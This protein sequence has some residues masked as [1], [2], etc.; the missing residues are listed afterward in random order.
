MRYLALVQFLDDDY[1]P[2]NMRQALMDRIQRERPDLYERLDIEHQ[3][4]EKE[5]K[6]GQ[7]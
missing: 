3:K 2:I 6:Q 7:E 1:F 5:Q 4:L